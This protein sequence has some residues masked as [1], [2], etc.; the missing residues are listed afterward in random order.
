MR[1][2]PLALDTVEFDPRAKPVGMA[3]R[4]PTGIQ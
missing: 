2:E 4:H 3:S 1:V